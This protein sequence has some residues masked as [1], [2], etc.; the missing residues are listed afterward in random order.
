LGLVAAADHQ[1]DD[2]GHLD[3]GHG[4]GQH[5]RAVRLADLM[6]DD[7]SVM[8]R[9]EHGTGQENADDDHDHRREVSPPGQDQGHDRQQRYGHRPPGDV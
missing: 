5:E 9:R 8:H 1:G 6:R 4:H 7:L 3:D 2:Q